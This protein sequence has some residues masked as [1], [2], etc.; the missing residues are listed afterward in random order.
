[1]FHL[2]SLLGAKL[3]EYAEWKLKTRQKE[4]AK[5]KLSAQ[6]YCKQTM[7]RMKFI[8]NKKLKTIIKTERLYKIRADGI[9]EI[10]ATSKKEV[11]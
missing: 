1:M 10:R 6:F 2:S 7:W 4:Y 8:G 9:L 3:A 5:L 11:D